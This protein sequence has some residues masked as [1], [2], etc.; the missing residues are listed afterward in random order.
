MCL[1]DLGCGN[2]NIAEYLNEKGL[3]FQYTGVDFSEVLL[4]A[5]KNAFPTG[6]FNCDD[7]N[8]LSLVSGQFDVGIY[9]HVVE[10]L[11]S[12]ESSLLAARKLC[13]KIIVRFFEPP[14]AGA[15]WG[16]LR[17]WMWA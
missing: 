2:A 13:K 10:M 16:K 6:V 8:R 7:V 12:T 9:S 11:P 5:A 4:Q 14:S 17:K 15:D 3:S 1:L